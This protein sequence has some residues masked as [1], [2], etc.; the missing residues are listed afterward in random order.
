[1]KL[2]I[3]AMYVFRCLHYLSF[4][5]TML[6]HQSECDIIGMYSYVHLHHDIE[7]QQVL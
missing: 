6:L 2:R 4:E 1:M 7:K 3:R 5:D